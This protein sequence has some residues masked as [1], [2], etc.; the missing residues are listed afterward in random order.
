V[1]RVEEGLQRP[2]LRKRMRCKAKAGVAVLVEIVGPF[3]RRD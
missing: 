3:S 2:I 1:F